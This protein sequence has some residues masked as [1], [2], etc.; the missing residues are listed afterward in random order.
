MI[1]KVFSNL[2]DSWGLPQPRCRTLHLALL[3]IMRFTSQGSSVCIP[4]FNCINCTSQL[5][6]ICK[7]AES[8]LNPTVYVTDE[9][10][11]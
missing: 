5:G 6:V 1:L 4:S 9:D 10:I 7:L 8:A 3:N 2:Y 11:K